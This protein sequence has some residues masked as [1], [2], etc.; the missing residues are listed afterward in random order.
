MCEDMTYENIL[1]GMLDQVTKDVDKREGSVIYDALAPAAYF[2]ADQ[3]FRLENYI[4]LFF[5]DTSVGE[6]LDR[7]VSDIGMVRNPA[8]FALRKV[9]TSGAI[10]I[11]SV[12][13]IEGI[14]YTITKA[15][16]E[17]IY[18]A[19]CNT[20]GEVG[21]IYSGEMNLI[22]G[23]T[24]VTAELTDII[25]AGVAEEMMQKFFHFGTEMVQLR[26]LSLMLNILLMKVWKTMCMS[27]LRKC[28]LLEP[29]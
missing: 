20:A 28:V 2:L 4:N 22:S 15:V 11:G 7:C 12:W 16:S 21:N 29:Q 6:Y 24:S 25:T 13:G 27:I 1:Q 10:D 19:V 17:N 5:A 3:Y 14:N 9:E 8:T 23:N 18:E 26:F